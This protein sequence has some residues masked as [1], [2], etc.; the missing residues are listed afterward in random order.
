MG[1]MKNLIHYTLIA[2]MF[3]WNVSLFA[4]NN[5]GCKWEVVEKTD[6]YIQE[7]C[8][9]NQV[10]IR[11]IA[12]EGLNIVTVDAPKNKKQ[13]PIKKFKDKVED[14]PKSTAKV[15]CE[16]CGVKQT[17]TEGPYFTTSSVLYAIDADQSPF[18]L[19]FILPSVM[20]LV[21]MF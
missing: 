1:T 3:N 9:E 5:E 20:V 13:N 10:R 21:A 15:D 18:Q 8:G 19:N 4:E 14:T 7:K 16:V 6:S 12:P 11:S 17:Y 2:I